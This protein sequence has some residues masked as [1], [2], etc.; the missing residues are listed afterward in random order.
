MVTVTVRSVD[1]CQVLAARRNPIHQGVRLLD[2]DESVDEDGV[3]LAVDEGR[4]CRR[5]HL[6]FRARGQVTRDSRYAGRHEHVPLQR[7]VS[8]SDFSHFF[9]HVE[10]L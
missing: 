2:R 9:G 7:E 3:P 1:R 6:L 4:R 8:R 10:S 5:P